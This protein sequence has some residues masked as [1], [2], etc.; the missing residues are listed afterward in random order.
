MNDIEKVLE[1]YKQGKLSRSDAAAQL[2]KNDD[3]LNLGFARIDLQ[4]QKRCGFPEVVYCAGKTVNQS[5]QI[6]SQLMSEYDNVIG[7]RASRDIYELLRLD[8][9]DRQY[10]ELAHLIYQHND[11]TIRNGERI[12]SVITAGTSDIP[13]AE[14]AAL[15]AEIMGNKVQR[16]YDV[17]VAGLHRLL[18]C[19]EDIRRANVCIVV[20]GMEGA[21]A[22][23]IGGLVDKAVIAVPTSIG[24][25]ASFHGLSA[26]LAMLNSCAAGVSV[27]N[28]DNGF[29]AGRLADI[30][31][32]MR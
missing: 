14:E 18:S 5:V 32:S 31:N 21:L 28:I 16:I 9:P 12:I 7:T 13:I 17:G 3:I 20:A 25:G 27:V 23:V 26:L 19:T 4:R 8:F 6:L 10:D 1:Q 24:Y 29:G 30:I 22:S 2:Q 11:R 15:T